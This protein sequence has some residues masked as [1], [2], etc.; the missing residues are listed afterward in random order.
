M[1]TNY[2]GITISSVVYKTL[3]NIMEDQIVDFL[4]LRGLLGEA[5]GAFRR[6]RRCEDHLF[7]LKGICAIQKSRKN[8]TFL[9]FLDISKA[10]DTLDRS[11]L[12]IHIY[13]KGLQGKAW[14]MIKMLYEKVDNRVIF[15]SLESD[16]FQVHSG[17]KQGCVLSPC[18]FNLVMT[19]LESM[20][21]GTGGIDVGAININGLYYADDI[22]LIA[23]NEEALQTMLDIA[24]TFAVKWNFLFN[25][26]KSK[27]LITGQRISNK[28]W[29]IG[30]KLLDET[31]NYKYLGVIINR[32][33]KDNN[34]ILDLISS[35]CSKLESYTR[36]TLSKH[37]DINR[38]DFG[39]SLWHSAI[40]PSLAHTSGTWFDD[41]A[42]TREKLLSSQYKCAKAVLR[43]QCNP[44]KYATLCELGWLPISYELDI[45]RM[46]YYKYLNNL[47]ELRLAK[48]VFTE[49]RELYN[50][51]IDTNFAYFKNIRNIC[52][53]QGLDHIFL[54]AG[55]INLHQ[56]KTFV[57]ANCYSEMRE[58]MSELPSLELFKTLKQNH[59]CS[60]YLT[61]KS[62]F[63]SIQL[64]F[65]LRTGVLGLGADIK[66]Q[67]RGSG[68]C[69]HCN[70]FDSYKHFI[71]YCNNLK[72][73]RVKMFQSFY[74]SLPDDV[75]SKILQNPEL[76]FQ[77]L[78]GDQN[79]IFNSVFLDFLVNAWDKR[80]T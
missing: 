74:L 2:R 36:Y 72:N 34:H 63:R 31:A 33:I 73:E 22:V 46:S 50:E 57:Q 58:K 18:L 77:L 1:L 54:N 11:L 55:D 28:K 3:V 26:K 52:Q 19:D 64:K 15:G 51:N 24:N 67:H 80:N 35:K 61:C 8:K 68:Q 48:I 65:K 37:S 9:A 60:P 53:S 4:E 42:T 25:D 16:V 38:V 29:Q 62:A 56:F 79:D 45:R 69:P 71:F 59:A 21:S 66:R 47:N 44:S 14:T 27:I 49:L 6:G 13:Q 43:L 23:P 17:V 39:N 12:F 7:T 20:L 70:V 10:F 41:T 5:Q 40:L 32:Q 78:L 30:N 76:T 75:F